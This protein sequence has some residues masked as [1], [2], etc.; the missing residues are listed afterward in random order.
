MNTLILGIGN[1]LLKD[2]GVGVHA[3]NGLKQVSLPSEIEILDGGT[4]GAD[5]VD[6]IAGRKKL[7]V[8]D[9]TAADGEPGTVYRFTIDD[10][11]RKTASM[12]SLH[13][14]GFVETY[15]MAKQLGC[16]PRE[17]VIFGV[18]P[19]EIEFGLELSDTVQRQI[20]RLLELVVEEARRLV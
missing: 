3:L 10:L 20:P 8:I 12:G 5:L 13:E 4:S 16:A 6:C 18:Q 17:I 9:A 11:I 15:L 2:E 1:V 7:I 14:F 19:A